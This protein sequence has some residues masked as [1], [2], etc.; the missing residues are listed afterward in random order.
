[1]L[2][3]TT[4]L[5]IEKPFCSRG[6]TD[7]EAP[8]IYL[9]ALLAKGDF[10]SVNPCTIPPRRWAECPWPITCVSGPDPVIWDPIDKADGCKSVVPQHALN[11]P[12]CPGDSPTPVTL[13]R[14]NADRNAVPLAQL[15]CRAE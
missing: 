3:S 5:P 8:L 10:H 1:M 6:N 13:D 14:Q 7:R 11:A 9:R 4:L 2:V 15:P 12:S